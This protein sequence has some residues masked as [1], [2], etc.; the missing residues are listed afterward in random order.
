LW[1]VALIMPV[2]ATVIQI[3]NIAVEAPMAAQCIVAAL[4]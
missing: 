2:A 3:L 4:W 1:V